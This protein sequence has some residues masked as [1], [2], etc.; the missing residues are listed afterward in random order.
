MIQRKPAEEG[1]AFQRA[2]RERERSTQA[3]ASNASYGSSRITSVYRCSFPLTFLSTEET[4]WRRVLTR[5]SLVGCFSSQSSLRLALMVS[6]LSGWQWII[7]SEESEN[8]NRFNASFTVYGTGFVKGSRFL[9]NRNKS[10]YGVDS[11]WICPIESTNWIN[12]PFQTI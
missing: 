11:S 6:N 8:C 1:D 10:S 9:R 5:P 2:A 12:N 3:D 4:S 7:W